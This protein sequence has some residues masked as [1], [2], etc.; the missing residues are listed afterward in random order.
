MS[1]RHPRLLV[2]SASKHERMSCV[3]D[4]LKRTKESLRSSRPFTSRNVD[5]DFSVFINHLPLV[6]ATHF[7]TLQH[8]QKSNAAFDR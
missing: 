5:V 2:F 3:P 1:V 6:L 7:C 4:D 8:D